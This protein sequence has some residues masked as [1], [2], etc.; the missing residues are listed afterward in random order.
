MVLMAIPGNETF[1]IVHLLL[2]INFTSQIKHH[3][4]QGGRYGQINPFNSIL[5]VIIFVGVIVGLFYL[6]KGVF[7]ILNLLSPILIILTLIIDY[8][9][10]TSYLKMLW[11][12]LKTN[13][14]MGI[15]LILLT[16]IAHPL[17]AGFPFCESNP[18]EKSEEHSKPI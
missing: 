4:T 9:V 14:L 3:M 15:G 16:I 11:N 5:S 7:Q 18:K 1:T 13:P 6:A 10:V 12:H 17:V 2:I 8:R